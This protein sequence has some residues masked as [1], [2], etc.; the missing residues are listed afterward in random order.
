VTRRW[1]RP[2]YVLAAWA[3][4]VGVLAQVFLAG[5]GVFQPRSAGGGSGEEAWSLHRNVGYAV[6]LLAVVVLLL[7]ALARLNRRALSLAAVLA[8]LALV[9][10]ALP[11]MAVNAASLGA[12]HPVNALLLFAIGLTLARGAL[13]EEQ[14]RAGD[15][16]LRRD[17]AEPHGAAD[18]RVGDGERRD[19]HGGREV[20]EERA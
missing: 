12:L 3:F 6:T 15:R 16:I 5:L 13:Y 20:L 7:A 8:I 9:Q 14:R 19:A 4:V 18:A 1:V 2:L 17:L 11:Y 10:T